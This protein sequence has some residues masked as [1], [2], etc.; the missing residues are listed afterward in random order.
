MGHPDVTTLIHLQMR[1]YGSDVD[2]LPMSYDLTTKHETIYPLQIRYCS[3]T[4]SLATTATQQE[5]PP[6]AK[7]G[8]L[9]SV[10]QSMGQSIHYS[11]VT[12]PQHCL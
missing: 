3:S 2:M 12:V 11:F 9:S 7:E 10:P 6:P 1:S 8:Q 4:L 5:E